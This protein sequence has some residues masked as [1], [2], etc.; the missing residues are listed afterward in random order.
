[1]NDDVRDGVSYERLNAFVD[2][3]LDRAEEGRVLEAIR[4][5]PELEQRV[6]ELRL[7]KD[8]IR[9]AYPQIPPPSTVGRT[10]HPRDWRWMAVAALA[11]VGVGVG[12]G[13]TGHAWQRLA[14]ESEP[15]GIAHRMGAAV[16]ATGT[17]KIVVHVSSSAPDRVTEMLDDV[18]GMLQAAR[19]ANRP[20]AIEILANNTGLD[21]LRADVPGPSARLASMRAENPNLS[22]VAC[23]QT[24]ERLRERGVV[25]QLLPET[26]VATT[27]LD[28]VVTRIHEGWTYIRT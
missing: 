27:A 26:T 24:I 18:E 25:V 15:P 12:A 2:G 14:G 9:H 19:T 7:M 16:Q 21:V 3:Q 8:L 11:L 22:L 5:E 10:G 13:W 28:E 1:M 4:H 20:I 17:D 23:R 6:S